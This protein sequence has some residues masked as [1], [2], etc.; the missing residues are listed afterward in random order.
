MSARAS[1]IPVF[2]P[3]LGCPHACVFCNQR[4]IS[5]AQKPAT[6]EDVKNSIEQ[7][8]AFLP[9][10]GK[11]QLA[12]Y[13][14]SFT[15]IPAEEQEALLTAAKEAL[16]RG[17]I[18]AIR[19]S[20]R[21]DAIDEAVLARLRRFGVET[22]EL[23]AQSMDDEVLRL[24]GRG[25]TAAD[26]ERASELVQAAGFRLILQ[27][28]TGL[29][30]STD[31]KDV[32]TARKIIALC[33]DGVRV[34][35]TVIV[36]D[37]ALCDMWRAG[38]YREHTVEDAVRVCAEILPLFEAAEIPVIRLGLNPTDELTG[39]AAVA[40]AYHPALGELVKSRILLNRAR[41]LLRGVEP[42]SRVTLTV[43]KGKTSQMAGQHRENVRRLTEEFGLAELKIRENPEL[44]GE[45]LL[46][47]VE[48]RA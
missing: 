35:P 18:D 30:G 38:D 36:R 9:R 26:V 47:S 29:P 23:G 28:M 42:G 48:K 19:L 20:T 41:A 11:R 39:G 15:A 32:E 13:G 1:I 21:P 14:G 8:A 5:G 31:E 16:D 17:R 3:H 46:F 27:M 44:N 34:Y 2:V 6:A 22:V 10:G 12:F 25:H 40:G 33:P 24:S 43:G 45:I 7:A 37:T 4:R